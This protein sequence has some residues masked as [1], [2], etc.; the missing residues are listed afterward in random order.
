QF[1]SANYSVSEN[2]GT[3]TIT[4][5]RVGGTDGTATVQFAT[6]SG[7]AVPGTDFTPVTGALVFGPGVTTQ[8]FT[9]KV[10]DDVVFQFSNKVLNLTLTNLLGGPGFGTP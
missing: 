10:R 1:S 2:G 7:T 4:V 8:P 9:V 5:T 3:A 6:T